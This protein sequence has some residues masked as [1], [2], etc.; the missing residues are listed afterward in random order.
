MPAPLTEQETRSRFI[1]P[2]LVN[3][4]WNL[5]KQI[6][7]EMKITDG[8]IIVRGTMHTRKA[9]KIADYAL[10]YKRNIPLAVVEAKDY[11]HSM[12]AGMQQA[13]QYAAMWDVPFAASSNG[14]GFV[15]HD[16]T[17][18]P[19]GVVEYDLSLD[20]F[21]SP[22]DLWTRLAEHKGLDA[23]A[24][25][26]VK[27]DYYTHG[28][29]KD[30]RYYQA[31]ATNRAVEAVA[32]GQ[33]RLLLVMATGT[34]KT[35]TAFQVIWRLREAGLAR[36]VLF[37]VD[38]NVLADQT[39]VN[40]FAPFGT[41]MTKI[42]SKQIDKSYE[43]YLA[44]Y[45][46]VHDGGD[47]EI[48]AY[49]DFSPDFFDLIVVDECHRGSA[50]A[51]SA[52]REILDYFHGATHVGLTATPRETADIS[53]IGYFGDPVYLYSLKTGI[54][55][56]F[57][58]PYSVVRLDL[59]KDLAGW[60]PAKNQVD[61]HGVRIADRAYEQ[62]DFDRSLVLTKR[63]ELVAQ[64]ITEYLKSGDRYAKTIVFCEDIDH[65]ERMRQ[66]LVNAN[67]DIA[68]HESRY[69]VR[70]TGDNPA[71]RAE[72][73]NFID[74]ESRFPVIATTSK[75]LSTGVDTQTCKV[76]VLDQNIQ[77]LTEFKQIIGR[78]TRI[79]EDYGKVA[80][81]IMDFRRAT[82]AFAD[83]EFDGEPES[84]LREIGEEGGDGIPLGDGDL[85]DDSGF[86]S[87]EV[88]EPSI[89]FVVDDV[90]VW[91]VG[92]RLQYYDAGGK[93]ITESLRDYTRKSVTEH[94]ASLGEFLK[95]WTSAE[96]KGAVIKELAG[97][98]VIFAALE[99]EVGKDFD[100]FDLICHVAFGRPPRTRSERARRAREGE[101]F[102]TYGDTARRVIEGLL[103][104]Y[105]DEG[106][107]AI[108]DATVFN[109]YPLNVVGTPKE[110]ID[111][112][113]GKPDFDTALSDLETR[114]YTDPEAA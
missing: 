56:G 6:R 101:Y 37:L 100:A 9:P 38:R 15:F 96:R 17:V 60:R 95:R 114:L 52:W 43:V 81:T 13:L 46:A 49:K 69:V 59:D 12:G 66:A 1:T 40:D 64:R 55:D 21:P 57:L 50:D 77:S 68:A 80:F 62:K 10:F 83:P 24:Q 102:S 29:K 58:A 16:S 26:L 35:Y 90:P 27:Q 65:A 97:H 53:N 30:A 3:A 109:L 71:G 84:I 11:Q 89:K 86:R 42:T 39:I 48:Q 63:T 107:T 23:D 104:K 32:R 91:L 75:L 44:L 110:I 31:V 45:Q 92:E 94:Y 33:K 87:D 51:N 36:R 76:I 78:G 93:L 54:E 105:A 7:E 111:S 2:A 82:E 106:I 19:G 103:D 79:R 61:K 20:Q 5:H 74:P 41:A 108:E 47:N 14:K 28:L 25:G 18:G 88:G 112:F 99:Y 72:I 85:P 67:A 98:G 34:G 70:I 22:E 4:G 113:G 8:R 73:D